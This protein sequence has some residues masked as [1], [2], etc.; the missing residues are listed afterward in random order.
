MFTVWLPAA[1]VARV[2][3]RAGE[4]GSTISAVVAQA[5]TEFLAR[6]PRIGAPVND[7]VVETRFVF[8]RHAASDVSVASTYSRP[9]KEECGTNG[10][11]R[12][13]L[14]AVF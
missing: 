6:G 14:V 4:S 9:S 5:L 8:D 12:V 2:R 3:Q 7:R 13:P 10:H 1:L 11:S